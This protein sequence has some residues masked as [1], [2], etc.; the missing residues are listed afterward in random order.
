MKNYVKL[1]LVTIL[2]SLLSACATKIKQQELL[3][4]KTVGVINKFPA[5]PNFVTIGTTIFNNEYADIKDPQFGNLLVETV[6]EYVKAR[7]FS[8]KLINESER[9]LYDMVLELIPRDVYATPG[10]YGFGVN[11]RSMFGN[12][13]QANTYVALNIGPYIRGKKK[14][15]ACYLQKLKPIPIEELPATWGELSEPNRVIITKTLR[16][17]IK[18]SL[19]EILNTVGI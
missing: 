1:F 16:A 3:T 11:Q 18:E 2:V 9:N 5:Y 4:V 8:V 7:G 6:L 13:M 10:T 17:N 15:S 12:P 19:D 14:C